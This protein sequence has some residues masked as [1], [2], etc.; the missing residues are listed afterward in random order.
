MLECYVLYASRDGEGKV[1][2][3]GFESCAEQLMRIRDKEG[4]GLLKEEIMVCLR[5]SP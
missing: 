3:G 1:A 4:K 2:E 5:E